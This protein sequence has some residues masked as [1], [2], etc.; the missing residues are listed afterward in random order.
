MSAWNVYGKGNRGS[1]CDPRPEV[2]IQG[3][4]RRKVV[5]IRQGREASRGSV[6]DKEQEQ[7]EGETARKLGAH[8]SLS[9]SQ[10]AE[11][12]G[13]EERDPQPRAQPRHGA[14]V[15]CH[16][17]HVGIGC[18]RIVAGD[19][20]GQPEEQGEGKGDSQEFDGG[21]LLLR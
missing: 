12:K 7:Q 9:R 17:N 4:R 20:R 13:S 11:N 3:G 18:K 1:R 15:G 6:A 21:L 8:G 2:G 14:P 19:F 16:R 5:D 10:C